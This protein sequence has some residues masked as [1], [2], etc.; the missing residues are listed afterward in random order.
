MYLL[1]LCGLDIKESKTLTVCGFNGQDSI[2]LRSRK[3]M[4]SHWEETVVTKKN[5]KSNTER[6]GMS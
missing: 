1:L 3:V 6:L 5:M 2:L 4:E